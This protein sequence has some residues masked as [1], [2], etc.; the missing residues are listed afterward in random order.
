[1][2][3]QAGGKEAWALLSSDQHCDLSTV[4]IKQVL[5]SLDES[6]YSLTEE[7]HRGLDFFFWVGC[8]YHKNTNTVLGGHI[9]V[10]GGKWSPWSNS[11]EQHSSFTHLGF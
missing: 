10:V 9:A 8:E 1:M 3:K 11:F 2:I 4:M 7:Q 6:E 5:I